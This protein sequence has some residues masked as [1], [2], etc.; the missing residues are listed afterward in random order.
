VSGEVIISAG[1]D[2]VS[3]ININFPNVEEQ[4]REQGIVSDNIKEKN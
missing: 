2:W 3:V 4:D 1:M